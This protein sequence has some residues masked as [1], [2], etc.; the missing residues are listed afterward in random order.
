MASSPVSDDVSIE[1][2]VD[3]MVAKSE[4]EAAREKW[5]QV[6]KEQEGM[7]C[8]GDVRKSLSRLSS[9]DGLSIFAQAYLCDILD[10]ACHLS[11]THTAPDCFL[12]KEYS[13]TSVER[14]VI[15]ARSC[16]DGV[17]S[18]IGRGTSRE[19]CQCRDGAG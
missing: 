16:A 7:S 4:K 5:V 1:E 19:V 6:L 15:S 13:A 12:N 10:G 3:M 17:R 9:I 11:R 2:F 8:V 14:F 18:K